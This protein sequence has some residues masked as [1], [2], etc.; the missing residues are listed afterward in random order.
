[1]I[2]CDWAIT[3]E[4][5]IDENTQIT[6]TLFSSKHDLKKEKSY[7]LR[8]VHQKRGRTIAYARKG[9]PSSKSASNATSIKASRIQLSRRK[10]NTVQHGERDL[11][12]SA[13]DDNSSR[14]EYRDHNPLTILG[15]HWQ[16]RQ[17]VRNVTL[18]AMAA[19]C[20]ANYV[21]KSRRNKKRENEKENRKFLEIV[22]VADARSAREFAAGTIGRERDT[23]FPTP[24]LLAQEPADYSFS[25]REAR[26]NRGTTHDPE[27][28]ARNAWCEGSAATERWGLSRGKRPRQGLLTA[29]L[30]GVGGQGRFAL[31]PALWHGRASQSRRRR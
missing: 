19:R 7:L 3:N 17:G 12:R 5:E 4:K 31:A 1:M 14:S 6:C 30:P 18:H 10:L 29:G 21:E 26:T 15:I 2:Q 20:H 28:R 9:T 24:G 23:F 11:P 13:P 22:G 25:P 16:H 27:R 8:H